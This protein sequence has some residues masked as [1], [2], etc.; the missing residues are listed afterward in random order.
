MYVSPP[1]LGAL[2][3]RLAKDEHDLNGK[4][5]CAA[6]KELAQFWKGEYDAFCN[7]KVVSREDAT[8]EVAVRIY[9]AYLA[10][11]AKKAL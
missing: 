4:R 11:L 7:L 9:H 5:Y 10:D 8:N 2:Q 6:E 1:S 3:N